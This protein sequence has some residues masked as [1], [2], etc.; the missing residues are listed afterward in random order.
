ML[1]PGIRREACPEYLTFAYAGSLLKIE[2]GRIFIS[3][4]GHRIENVESFFSLPEKY[5]LS[6]I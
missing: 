5:F 2:F 1:L 4:K 3:I 6:E